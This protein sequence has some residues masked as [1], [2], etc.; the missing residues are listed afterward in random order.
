MR[1]DYGSKPTH[2]DRSSNDGQ[3][4]QG[5]VFDIVQIYQP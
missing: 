5:N 3:I 2:S 4:F 1:R